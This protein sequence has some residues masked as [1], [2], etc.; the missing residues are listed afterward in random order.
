MELSEFDLY[1]DVAPAAAGMARALT[2]LQRSTLQAAVFRVLPSSDGSGAREADV[3]A[4]I[5]WITRQ[6][7]F[8]PGW[9]CLVVGLRLLDA[10]AGSRYGAS[11]HACAT[12]AQ[13]DLLA[14][15]T[16]VPHPT[17]RRFFAALVRLAV[18]GFLSPPGY[19]GNRR[20]IGFQ[21]MG[22]VDSPK[23]R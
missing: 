13:D 6:A 5:D 20:H 16:T 3:M 11:F 19:P 23:A 15:L 18:L 17:V 12:A 1:A 22:Y 8:E 9:P 10:T 7:C 4:F 2:E 21:Y 14:G